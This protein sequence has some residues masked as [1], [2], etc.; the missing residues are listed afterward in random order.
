MRKFIKLTKAL[1]MLLIITAI[2]SSAPHESILEA[3]Y[4]FTKRLLEDV[5]MPVIGKTRSTGDRFESGE[6]SV[7]GDFVPDNPYNNMQ[8]SRQNERD[9][10]ESG[11]SYYRDGDGSYYIKQD[12]IPSHEAYSGYNAKQYHDVQP[13]DDM[14]VPG[15]KKGNE[16]SGEKELFLT[17]DEIKSFK[18]IG[19][20][21][22][23]KI[24]AI[25]SKIDK[26]SIERI[27][28]ILDGGITYNEKE[29][30]YTIL[31]K[32][33]KPDHIDELNNIIEK[34]KNRLIQESIAER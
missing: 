6:K 28:H 2:I 1:L 19:L 10:F 29:E 27:Y 26:S 31:R 13:D 4:N 23:I 9:G 33:L 12:V 20:A 21:D 17:V 3:P 34:N 11:S 30:I 25:I 24:M 5:V 14:H 16:D 15:D 32:S 18:N 7:S 8:S 22:K